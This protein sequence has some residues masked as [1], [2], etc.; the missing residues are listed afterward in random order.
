M[1]KII[2]L[3]AIYCCL[4]GSNNVQGQLLRPGD[5]AVTMSGNVWSNNTPVPAQDYVLEILRTR[6]TST[7][8]IGVPIA[9]M[10]AIDFATFSYRD[11]S[12]I[13][14]TMGNIFGIA[15]DNNRN[16]YTA[17]T[18]FY[19]V[20][21]AGISTGQ[22][23]KIDALTGAVTS[24]IDLHAVQNSNCL[25]NLKTYGNNL[26]VANLA[27]GLI[28][29]INL[30]THNI[31]TTFKPGGVS[32]TRKPYGLAIRV[33]GGNARLFYS[34][35]EFNSSTTTVNSIDIYPTSFGTSEQ[36]EIANALLTSD[37][38][39]FTDIA[40]SQDQN[41]MIVANKSTLTW[42]ST[43]AHN[44]KVAEYEF[45]GVSWAI[46]IPSFSIPMGTAGG[47]SFSKAVIKKDG[48]LK[49]DTTI[50]TT[51]DCLDCGT[52][53][54]YGIVG[55]N[56]SAGSGVANGV[57]VDFDNDLTSQDKYLLGDVEVCDT[58]ID[59]SNCKCGQ[60]GSGFVNGTPIRLTIPLPQ[61]GYYQGFL[62][63][64]GSYSF[65]K[66]QVAGE[67]MAGY[68]FDGICENTSKIWKLINSTTNT[69]IATGSTWPIQLAAYNSLPCGSYKFIITPKI[70]NRECEACEFN[71]NIVCDPPSCCPQ[72]TQIT[73]TPRDA[74]YNSNNNPNMWGTYSQ[75]FTINSNTPMSEIRIDVEHFE[76]N[77]TDPNCIPC[78]N[79]PKTWGSLL[80]AAYNG[81]GFVPALNSTPLSTTAA[82][83]NNRDLVYKPGSL[84][85]IN[86]ANLN[87]NIAM[88]NASPVNCCELTANICLKITFKDANC[89]E[90]TYMY[91]NQE[92]PIRKTVNGNPNGNPVNQINKSV[93]KS[94]F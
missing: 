4:L 12:W 94:N 38:K 74:T 27:N 21:V 9:P 24:F 88:P 90:C 10:S 18:G 54:V 32:D 40:F 53:Q 11:P 55:F 86:N 47:L 79:I 84:F 17:A 31:V 43:M 87:V 1:K 29:M 93:I 59:C 30:T 57:C 70:G 56:N 46:L 81:N 60:W 64:G 68:G 8:P 62:S 2:Y 16:I 76:I 80:G 6:N 69:Q 83:S 35:N 67:L 72:Q 65:V 71:I 42:L 33:V 49:C 39:P 75:A 19:G 66:G 36:V 85:N 25:G 14:S 3:I 92:I 20:Q 50:W 7:L 78:R 48:E 52:N 34:M 23:W 41:K 5:A 37:S 28:Y 73:I 82:F 15:I 77:S 44:T 26:F 91:C 13:R 51:A 58:L 61:G 22:I 63:C 45:N 89:R